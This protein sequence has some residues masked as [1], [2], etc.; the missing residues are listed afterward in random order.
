M[1]LKLEP[2]AMLAAHRDSPSSLAAA[3]ARHH[4]LNYWKATGAAMQNRKHSKR[5]PLPGR[6]VLGCVHGRLSGHANQSAASR[7]AEHLD[8]KCADDA[9][10]ISQI[11]DRAGCGHDAAHH[12]KRRPLVMP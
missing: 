3:N 1:L 7:D 8:R 12:Y 5:P 4:D 10:Q 6:N 11:G 9:G 2:D